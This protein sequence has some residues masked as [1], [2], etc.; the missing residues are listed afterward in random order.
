MLIII[1]VNYRNSLLINIY[2]LSISLSPEHGIWRRDWTM[3]ISDV[4]GSVKRTQL[5]VRFWQRISRVNRIRWLLISYKM[6]LRNTHHSNFNRKKIKKL[7]ILNER[8][9]M[10]ILKLIS[11]KYDAPLPWQSKFE[12]EATASRP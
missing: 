11:I 12:S 8:L 3:A 7:F 10:Y 4:W 6:L 1:T 5:H 2:Y 9:I